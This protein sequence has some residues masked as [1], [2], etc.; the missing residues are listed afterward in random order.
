MARDSKTS[1]RNRGPAT[2]RERLPKQPLEWWR[3]KHAE[4]FDTSAVIVMREALATVVLLGEPSWRAAATGDASAAIGLAL[5]LNP[6]RS[7][8]NAY[9]L[10]MTALA[11]CAGGGS[12]GAALVLSHVMRKVPNSNN[13]HAA[14]ATSWLMRSFAQIALRDDRGDAL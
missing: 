9:D 5:R 4:F 2:T 6:Q 14:I 7:T 1:I 8:A 13:S 11:A 3:T 12:D 10:I